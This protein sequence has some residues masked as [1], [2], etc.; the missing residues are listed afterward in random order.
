[1]L[2]LSIFTIIGLA[3]VKHIQQISNTKNIAFQDLDLYNNVRAGI[4]LLRFDLSQAFHILYE[5]LGEENRQAVS[6]NIPVART[7]FDGRKNE[8]VF[9]SL[10]HRVYYAGLR[11]CDQ[12][13]ISYFLQKRP[14]AKLPTLMKRESEMIDADLYKSG[15]IYGLIDNVESLEFQYWDEKSGKWQD[16][17]NSDSGEFRDRFPLAVKMKL[18][19]AGSSAKKLTLTSEFKISFPNNTPLLVKF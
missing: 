14:N 13:E 15:T 18:T 11:E 19:V 16:D 10:S 1:M 2:A 4:S 3:T 7:L 12:T 9:T 8:L 6:Q 5:E 17:W